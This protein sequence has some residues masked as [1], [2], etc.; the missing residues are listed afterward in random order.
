MRFHRRGA[1]LLVAAVALASCQGGGA[2]PPPFPT[3]QGLPPSVTTTQSISPSGGTVA[4][5]LGAAT[6]TVI[7]PNGALSAQGT[8]AITVYGSGA[9]KTLQS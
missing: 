8:V 1:L 9:P 4:A 6:V 3:G 2:S 7:V 5:T